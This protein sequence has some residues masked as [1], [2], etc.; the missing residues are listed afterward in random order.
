MDYAKAMGWRSGENPAA[1]RGN[2]NL[3]LPAYSKTKNIKH[4]AALSVSEIPEFMVQL[5]SREAIV[6]KLL[7]FIILT[8]ARSGEARLATWDEIDFKNRLWTISAARMKMSREHIVP[9]SNSAISV[10]RFVSKYNSESYIFEHPEKKTSF[11]YNATRALL[12]RMH[13]ETITT[14]GFRSTFSCLLYTS[15]SPRD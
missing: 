11:S 5:R 12:K 2:L 7:E 1:W 8:A 6:S 15:P 9:L 14:H 4:H 10:L 3:L 13:R